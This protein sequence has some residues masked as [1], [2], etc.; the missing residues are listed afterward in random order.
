VLF[1]SE[2]APQAPAQASPPRPVPSS[3]VLALLQQRE[4]ARTRRDWASADAF[5]QQL[6]TLGWQVGDS[7]AGPQLSPLRHTAED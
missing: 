6:L 2:L 3:E 4:S 5:R 7:P 1:R